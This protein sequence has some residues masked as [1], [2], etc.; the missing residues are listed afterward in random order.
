MVMGDVAGTLRGNSSLLKLKGVSAAPHLERDA[1][2]LV[3]V[4]VGFP[5]SFIVLIYIMF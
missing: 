4:A 2:C 3:V 1:C 5:V